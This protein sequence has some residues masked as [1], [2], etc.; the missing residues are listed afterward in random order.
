MERFSASDTVY[1]QYLVAQRKQTAI[2][3]VSS[4]LQNWSIIK[5][6]V[7]HFSVFLFCTNPHLNN[8]EAYKC[9]ELSCMSL[10]ENMKILSFFCMLDWLQYCPNIYAKMLKNCLKEKTK[11]QVRKFIGILDSFNSY[12]RLSWFYGKHNINVIFRIFTNLEEKN[13]KKY[14]ARLRNQDPKLRPY[15]I[16]RDSD[17]VQQKNKL[18]KVI[19][20]YCL[21]LLVFEDSKQAGWIYFIIW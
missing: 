18:E 2:T 11:E 15:C 4:S 12:S 19:L 14:Y 17:D 21:L 7:E 10:R 20:I 3:T 13:T 6:F 9:F 8:S 5:I 1:N 16:R